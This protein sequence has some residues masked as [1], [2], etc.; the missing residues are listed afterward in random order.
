M[1][2]ELLILHSSFWLPQTTMIGLFIGMVLGEIKKNPKLWWKGLV[3]GMLIGVVISII[4]S[5]GTF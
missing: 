5:F 2:I 1:S 3:I 4:H